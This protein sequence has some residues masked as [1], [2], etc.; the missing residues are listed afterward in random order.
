MTKDEKELVFRIGQACWWML[1]SEEDAAAIDPDRVNRGFVQSRLTEVIRAL[2][3]KEGY[4]G[5][6]DLHGKDT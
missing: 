6:G 3:L 4:V 2:R 1:M 5:M